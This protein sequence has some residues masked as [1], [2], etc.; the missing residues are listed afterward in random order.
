MSEKRKSKLLIA[1]LCV[2][3]ILLAGGIF[4][5]LH[6]NG[7][8]EE[9]VELAEETESIPLVVETVEETESISVKE[10]ETEIEK[11]SETESE[12]MAETETE[13]V[14]ESPTN[15][16]KLQET[17]VKPET[18]KAEEKPQNVEN[19]QP[20][21][22][23]AKENVSQG[24]QP[25]GEI[26]PVNDNSAPKTGDM[27]DGMMYVEGFGWGVYEGEGSGTY[28]LEIYENGNKIGS[29]D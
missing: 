25:A 3:C 27:K 29:M 23:E 9:A 2:V 4:W 5:G 10:S 15:V 14:E 21:V 6:R 22:P 24:N 19:P 26:P 1:G 16:Q 7:E 11:M 8:K 17:P 12:A 20:S 13:T 28:A 18:P